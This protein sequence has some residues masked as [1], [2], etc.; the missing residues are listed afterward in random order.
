[1]REGMLAAVRRTASTTAPVLATVGFVVLITGNTQTSVH[2]YATRD[3]ASVRAEAAVVA[4][5]GTP[6]LSDAA[7][8]SVPGTGLLA[9]TVYGGA[10]KTPMEAAGIDPGAFADVHH[11]LRTVSGS[12]ARLRGPGTVA[13]TESALAT[14]G[15]HTSAEATSAE[16]TFEDGRTER[17]RIVAVLADR[18]APTPYT[19]LLPRATVRAHD[20]SALTDVVYRTG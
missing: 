18:M 7:V 4:R 6:G 3:T 15:G 13:V 8:G 16:V 14:L 1:M 19:A 12:L 11:R 17:L 10:A 9:T 20:P 2:S 5:D